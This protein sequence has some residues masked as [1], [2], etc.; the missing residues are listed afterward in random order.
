[1]I[2][3]EREMMTMRWSGA[4][5][6]SIM[7]IDGEMNIGGV[8]VRVMKG[9]GIAEEIIGTMIRAEARVIPLTIG[10]G[11]DSYFGTSITRRTH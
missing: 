1:M 5:V 10:V 6:E 8:V 3:D 7:I 11:G 2:E 9:I 4:E